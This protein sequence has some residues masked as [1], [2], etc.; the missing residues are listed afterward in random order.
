M[1]DLDLSSKEIERFFAVLKECD[2]IRA[3]GL[4]EGEYYEI[5][6]FFKLDTLNMVIKRNWMLK[7]D[8]NEIYELLLG[9]TESSE[10]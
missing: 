10:T 9:L 3:D 5:G 6:Q 7:D 1:I 2:I 8:N 4:P